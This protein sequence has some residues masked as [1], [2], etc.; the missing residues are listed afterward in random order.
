MCGSTTSD[1]TA[2][3]Q[4]RGDEGLRSAQRKAVL[5]TEMRSSI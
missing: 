3:V 2:E 1:L 4:W 5:V